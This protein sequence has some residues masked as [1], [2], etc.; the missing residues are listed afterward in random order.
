LPTHVIDS[1]LFRDRYVS[2]EMRALFGDE[3]LVQRWLDVEA[4]LATVEGRL[5]LIPAD[6]AAEIARKAKVELLDFPAL[7]EAITAAAHPII[8]L[9]RALAAVCD[10]EAGEYVHWGATTQDIQ[11]TATALQLRDAYAIV[12]RD[13]GRLGDALEKLTERHRDTP[14]AGRTHGQHAVPIT[15]GFKTAVWLAEV[16][17]HAERLAESRERVLVGQFSG[18]V[19]T[20][21]ALGEAGLDVQRLLLDELALGVPVIAW[22]TAR[23]GIA[24]FV[25]LLGLLA[26]T[27]GKIA[28]E[29][30]TLQ[31]TEVL[32]V[33]EPWQK[34]RGGSSTMP[35]KR[36]PMRS[37]GI[38]ANTKVV[39]GQ[40]PIMLGLMGQEHERDMRPWLAERIVVPEACV[41]AAGALETLAEILEGLEVYPERMRHNL[42]ATRGFILSEQVMMELAPVIGR[43]RAHDLIY[44]AAMAAEEGMSLR[45]ALL[46]A[47]ELA[48]RVAELE[49]LLDPAAYTGL[50]AHFA[51]EVL[52]AR[53][54]QRVP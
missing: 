44:D 41:L 31:K 21:A 34:G 46:A 10:G 20:M 2:A 45:D 54:R 17:R 38:V 32:E 11:D 35:H 30:V 4:A 37:Q 27:V 16:D 29:I 6:A 14:M 15:F 51:D 25:S 47:P 3:A 33:E 48:G 36:N 49:S 50:S 23:D 26:G 8:A 28:S 13:L 18:A 7:A 43:Q 24:E 42:E 5:G 12:E 19:G 52:R 22:H 1:V 40:V 39:Q 53:R 9:I